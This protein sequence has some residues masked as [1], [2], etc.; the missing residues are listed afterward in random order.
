MHDVD[1]LTEFRNL[2][3]KRSSRFGAEKRY[4]T[5]VEIA[6]AAAIAAAAIAKSRDEK[7]LALSQAELA[8]K[9]LRELMDDAVGADGELIGKKDY[10]PQ[11]NARV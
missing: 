8:A 10:D 6:L 9:Q 1:E 4:L 11:W 5:G 3:N 7:E 2:L